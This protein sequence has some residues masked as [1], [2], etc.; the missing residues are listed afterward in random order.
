MRKILLVLPLLLPMAFSVNAQT[1]TNGD[2]SSST[3]IGTAPFI[4][5]AGSDAFS[6]GRPV[7]P[8]GDSAMN[9]TLPITQAGGMTQPTN[10]P[11]LPS[12]KTSLMMVGLV[13]DA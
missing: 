8:V 6:Y 2:F 10:G 11:R 1:I 13:L 4:E 9:P 7:A 3:N 5:V 12:R